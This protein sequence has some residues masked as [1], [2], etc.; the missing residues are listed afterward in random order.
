M[1][2]VLVP[3]SEESGRVNAQLEYLES[4]PIDGDD[5]RVTV[6]HSYTEER[7]DAEPVEPPE[8]LL[9]ARERL[10]AMNVAAEE[11]EISGTPV[12][13]IPLMADDL[14]VDAIVMSGRKRSPAGK[15]LFGSVTQAVILDTDRPVTVVGG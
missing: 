8:T 12:D 14:D 7:L 10:E 13:G 4:L 11:R 5:L 6:A 15:L 2:H 3:I 1:Y 9:T